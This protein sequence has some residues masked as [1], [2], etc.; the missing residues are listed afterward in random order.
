MR[1]HIS[2]A[3]VTIS[4]F[5]M[6]CESAFAKNS[7]RVQN[8]RPSHGTTYLS[9]EDAFLTDQPFSNQRTLNRVFGYVDYSWVKDPWIDLDD[10][11]KTR[12]VPISS[13]I[14]RAQILTLG[15]G[16]L[17]NDR[18]QL[19]F[20]LPV[21]A[22]R[23]EQNSAVNSALNGD[24]SLGLGDIRLFGKWRFFE[25]KRF[26]LAFSP[27]LSLPTGF[28]RT[29]GYAARSCPTCEVTEIGASSGTLSASAKLLAEV[30]FSFLRVSLNAGYEYHP[31]A[32]IQGRRSTGEYYR[33]VD[34]TRRIPLGVG[35]FVPIKDAFGLNL[36]GTYQAPL[37]ARNE[38]THPGE[39]LAGLRYWPSPEVSVHL[40]A[41]RGIN[42]ENSGN[43]PRFLAGVK[44]PLWVPKANSVLPIEPVVAAPAPSPVPTPAPPPA[45]RRAVITAKAIEISQEVTFAF[46]TA[47]LTPEGMQTLDDVAESMK[48]IPPSE[49]IE[50]AGHTDHHGGRGLNLRLS[51]ARA[52]AVKKYLTTRGIDQGRLRTK[53]YG[54]DHPKFDPKVSSQDEISKN[55]R[56]EFNRT[57]I[58]PN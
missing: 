10:D 8:L 41:A 49:K 32:Y 7:I 30:R 24:S 26:G 51:F 16:W 38:Y 27:A 52:N 25:S 9:V 15:A 44:F 22:L 23:T 2:K 58:A 42:S 39:V 20:E 33:K 46:G 54:P 55:R 36:E 57:N 53:G 19:D 47:A 5:F 43:S 3:L 4:I 14:N 21:E 13:L 11:G 28:G 17:V 6:L 12:V 31:G 48:E 56:V 50:V 37:I 29:N 35:F 1:P 45:P 34:F 18:F 40:S